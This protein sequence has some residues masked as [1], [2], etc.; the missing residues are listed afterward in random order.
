[1]ATI[2]ITRPHGALARRPVERSWL[3]IAGS[4]RKND[5]FLAISSLQTQKD[6][7]A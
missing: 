1:M 2:A 5:K 6:A 3:V 4:A 7:V